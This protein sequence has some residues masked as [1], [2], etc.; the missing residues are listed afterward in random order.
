[1]K[2][3]NTRAYHKEEKKL[4]EKEAQE[5]QNAQVIQFKQEISKFIWKLEEEYE[6]ALDPHTLYD[7]YNELVKS[8]RR[9]LK[10]MKQAKCSLKEDWKIHQEIS[11]A[12]QKMRMYK[13]MI[14]N[15]RKY[16][17]F[18]KLQKSQIFF[19]NVKMIFGASI[20]SDEKKTKLM[21]LR[22]DFK[23]LQE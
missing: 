19:E 20:H 9:R 8:K 7:Q 12:E 5:A 23:M 1:M 10:D 4:K 18:Q 13:D 14:G 17:L 21:F 15:S 2:K 3:I 11:N 22:E 16:V 6:N